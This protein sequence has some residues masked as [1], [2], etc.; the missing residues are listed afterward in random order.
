MGK[1]NPIILVVNVGSTSLKY[2]LFDMRGQTCLAKG[3]F[4][5]VG[6]AR[7]AFSW[8]QKGMHGSGEI[9]TTD[10]LWALQAFVGSR[11]L[12]EKAMAA[13]D[14]NIDGIIDTSDAL[15]ILQFAV[16]LRDKL[17]TVDIPDRPV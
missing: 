14:V 3:T 2:R 11:T 15:A 8:E 16:K 7:S 17:P 4:D 9:D 10:A 6:T 5:R 12:D 1:E 13:A